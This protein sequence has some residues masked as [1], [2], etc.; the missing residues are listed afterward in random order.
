MTKHPAMERLPMRPSGPITLL[1]REHVLQQL[2][3]ATMSAIDGAG[4]MVLVAGEAGA[5]KT[6]VV[7]EFV[8]SLANRQ[9]VLIGSCDPLTTPRPLGPL[10]DIAGRLGPAVEQ[11]LH[12]TL[13]GST[14]HELFSSVLTDLNNRPTVLVIEDVHWADEATLDLLRFLAYRIDHT[15][16]LVVMSYRADEI[17]RM[18]PLTAMLGDVASSPTIRRIEVDRLS[19]GAVAELSARQDIDVDELFRITGG[20]AFFVTE[21][22]AANASIP[23]TVRAAVQG[24]LARLSAPAAAAVEALAVIGSP[25]N[26]DLVAGMVATAQVG[27]GEAIDRG[28]LHSEKGRVSFRHELGRLAVLDT[29][30]E[31]R[32]IELH[33]DVME[34]LIKSGVDGDD[35]AHVVE[36]AEHAGDDDV[37]LRYA[38][39]AGDRAAALGA[40]REAAAHYERALRFLE[41]LPAADQA[42]LLES[43]ILEYYW[44]GQ[45]QR[46]TA[47]SDALLSLHRTA[48]DRLAEGEALRTQSHLLWGMGRTQGARKGA[49][50][51][52]RVLQELSP[53]PELARAYASVIELSFLGGDFAA[54]RRHEDA[55]LDLARRLKI[56][57]IEAWVR[58]FGAA[59]RS[60]TTDADWDSLAAIRRRIVANGWLE[61]EPRLIVVEPYLATYRHDP[62][63]AL[64]LLD[65]AAE[66]A[67]D[68]DRWG[69][70]PHLQGCRSYALLQVGDWSAA[71]ASAVLRDPSWAGTGIAP[72]VVHGL[73]RARRGTSEAWPILDEALLRIEDSD[74]SRVG[75]LFEARAEA[76]WLAGKNDRA[77]GEA[78]R[79]LTGVGPTADPWQAGALA[80]WVYR[81]GGEVPEI[82]MAEPYALE[83]AG[84]WAGA[85]TAF[86][87]RGLPY[88][89]ALARLGGNAAAVRAALNTFTHL[90]AH[91]PADRA[92]TRLRELGERRGTRGP[93]ASSRQNTFGLTS[94]QMDVLTLIAEGCS[95]ADIADRLVLSPNTVAHHVSTILTKLGVGN[96]AEAASK[97]SS[98][99]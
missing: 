71:E 13:A 66:V 98:A 95:N 85:A 26:A 36:H 78:L 21:V 23:T 91:V 68:R 49:E 15:P 79:G 18:H 45:N 52:L 19:R 11:A 9:R 8:R 20:N 92:R 64:P 84:D 74:L 87:Q 70:L 76:A 40:H 51:S 10:L 17:G 7:A 67:E 27:L 47:C 69:I 43:A 38:Q 88:D 63:R 96:R 93:R 35:L 90:G 55:A 83:I 81:A 14:V 31:F 22:L 25:A 42:T 61:R 46:A 41:S 77:I 53:G 94:R 89:A 54:V 59:S 80:G 34:L 97:L 28:L 24:R 65:E 60:L 99:R 6:S 75:P 58:Y 3:A 1:E 86:Q 5:G 56:P 29:I 37:L 72:K 2:L 12:R 16:V 48:G 57:E 73:L 30:P 33:R 50:Q 44:G 62:L 32:K 4:R 39:A 82:P